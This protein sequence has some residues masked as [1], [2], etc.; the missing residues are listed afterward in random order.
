MMKLRA[1]LKMGGVV[2]G[3]IKRIKGLSYDFGIF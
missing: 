1:N 2:S 3:F